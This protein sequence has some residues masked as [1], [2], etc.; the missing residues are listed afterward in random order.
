[1]GKR[2]TADA[3]TTI[4]T[5]ELAAR[6]PVRRTLL[7]LAGDEATS[8]PLPSM[9][10]VTIGRGTKCDITIDHPTLSRMH[11]ALRLGQT[12]AVIDRA[13][14]NGTQLRGARLPADTPVVIS[15][16]ETFQAGD[17]AFVVQEAT[18][19]GE[20]GASGPRAASGV[21]AA[22]Q[23]AIVDAGRDPAMQRLYE[24][25]ERVARGTIGVLVLGETGAGKEVLAEYVHRRSPRAAAPLVRI[26]CA[27]LSETLIE[28]ELFGHQKGAFTGATAD[29]VGL[30]EA[31]DGGSVLLD[32]VGELPL[33]TQAKLLR[34]L[35]D[36]RVVRVGATTPREV[37]VRFIAATNRDLEAD[38]TAGAFRRDLYFRLAGAVLAIPP[39]R[40]RRSEIEPLARAFLADAAARA[41]IAPPALSAAALTA[42]LAHPWTGNIRELKSALERAVLV[43]DTTIDVTALALASPTPPPIST[44]SLSP[45]SVALPAEIEALEKQRILDAL[46]QHGGNQ[47]RAAEAI[48]MPR[49][50]FVKRLAQYGIARP[51]R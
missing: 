50:T 46:A 2:E 51:R 28:S 24:V 16:Y 12:I 10:E 7:A 31:A 44:P 39:L 5:P 47:T 15:S 3:V 37:D 17:V 40:A 9:G 41:G 45:A 23:V 36:R 42:L 4:R 35:E 29:R 48:G 34:V 20:R 11:F 30:I 26:N 19:S 18:A 8:Y 13:S 25:A 21:V 27:A 33:A 14:A 38:I 22:A 1:M 43:A 49:R 6:G 32:E